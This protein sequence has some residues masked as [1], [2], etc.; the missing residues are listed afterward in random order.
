[1]RLTHEGDLNLITDSKSINFGVDSEVSLTHV[2]NLGLLLNSTRGIFF[3]DASNLDQFIRSGGSDV[4]QI[5]SPTEIDITATTIDMNGNLDVSGSITLGGTAI[6][7]TVE[8]N[9]L[10]GVTSTASELNLLDGSTAGTV[11]ASKAVVV[12]SNKDITGLET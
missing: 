8:L 2:H 4:L 1:M 6:T 12:D 5:A 9:I 11:V 10:D 3:D 7:S